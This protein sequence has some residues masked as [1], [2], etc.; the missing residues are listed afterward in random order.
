MKSKSVTGISENWK[1]TYIIFILVFIIIGLVVYFEPKIFLFLFTTI[2]G[3]V[4]LVASVIGLGFFSIYFAIG[5]GIIFLILF[6]V[7]K[8]KEGIL[9]G[10]PQYMQYKGKGDNIWPLDVINDFQSF[11]AAHNPNIFFDMKIIQKQATADEARSF[12]K[13]GKWPWSEDV[14]RK[15]KDAVAHNSYISSN[16][17]T[18]LNDAQIV[19]NENA[20]KQLLTWNTKEGDFLICGVTIGHPKNMPKNINNTVKCAASLDGDTVMHK[21]VYTGY[22][23]I[24]GV[25]TYNTSVVPNA[26]I[27]SVVPGFSFLA[28]K[29][30]C[31]PC[32]PLNSPPDYSCPFIIDTGN[33]TEISEIWEN[34]RGISGPEKDKD[35]DAEK[36]KAEKTYNIIDNSYLLGVSRKNDTS[37]DEPSEWN[38]NTNFF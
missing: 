24:N 17:G 35:K 16:P 22:S 30:V 29:G 15:Y 36:E 1:T 4:L 26:E 20:I 18:S 21:T 12:L 9:S 13:N 28:E 10:I 7:S 34:L 6:M 32:A 38:V 8:I 3:N 19:Y 5:I 14:Q 23:G 31:N 37:R 27:P 33:G 11:Q 2:L 25:M